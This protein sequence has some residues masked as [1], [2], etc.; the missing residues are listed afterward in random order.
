MNVSKWNDEK[1]NNIHAKNYATAP[2]SD[3]GSHQEK[4][5]SDKAKPA[6]VSENYQDTIKSAARCGLVSCSQYANLCFSQCCVTKFRMEADRRKLTYLAG[7]IDV[8]FAVC[9]L[10]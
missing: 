6:I 4:K 7:C 9:Q 5:R 2:R 1:I 8:Q 10:R 3:E